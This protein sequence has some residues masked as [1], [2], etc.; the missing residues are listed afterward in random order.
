[1]LVLFAQSPY[2]GGIEAAEF[3]GGERIVQIAHVIML[4]ACSYST[5]AFPDRALDTAQPWRAGRPVPLG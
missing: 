3:D 5:G 4:D 2:P 1:M